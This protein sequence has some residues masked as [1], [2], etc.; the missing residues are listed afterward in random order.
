MDPAS[1]FA[2]IFYLFAAIAIFGN[3]WAVYNLRFSLKYFSSAT[4]Y[5]I[6]ILHTTSIGL[7]LTTIPIIFTYVQGLCVLVGFGHYALG[8]VNI[9]AIVLIAVVYYRYT[10][11]TD[12]VVE[13]NQKKKAIQMM[14]YIYLFSFITLLPLSTNSYGAFNGVWCTVNV[15]YWA[16]IIFYM[17]VIPAL[18]FCTTILIYVHY[19]VSKTGLTGVTKK[20]YATLGVYILITIFA[21]TPRCITRILGSLDPSYELS[22]I[23]VFLVQI[24]LNIGGIAY[25]VCFIFN[26]D[27]ILSFEKTNSQSQSSIDEKSMEFTLDDLEAVTKTRAESITNPVNWFYFNSSSRNNSVSR[28]NSVDNI[29]RNYSVTKDLQEKQRDGVP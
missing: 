2:I 15:S 27:S 4:T 25:A 10:N 6:F 1:P 18:I 28:T 24:P 29:S 8:L 12:L 22:D 21:F 3:S 16:Y 14:R 5:L 9:A 26:R 13:V 7:N 19:N 20:L 23:G 17:W 11:S